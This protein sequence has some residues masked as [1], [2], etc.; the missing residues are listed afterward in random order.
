M[1]VVASESCAISAV[2][3]EFIRD[4]EPGEILIF[5]RD[6]IVSRWEHCHT[7]KKTLCIFE[8]IYLNQITHPVRDLVQYNNS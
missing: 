2:G 1:Y 5:S 7:K 6:G 3:A 8:Y 4:V